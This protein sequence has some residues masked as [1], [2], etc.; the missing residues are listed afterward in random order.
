MAED[1]TSQLIVK[2]AAA[3]VASS[4]TGDPMLALAGFAGSAYELVRKVWKDQK[5]ARDLEEAFQDA[6]ICFAWE[7]GKKENNDLQSLKDW[8]GLTP[9]LGKEIKDLPNQM[10]EQGI[11]QNL[12][13]QFSHMPGITP[14]QARRA[15]DLYESCL[16]KALGP[17]KDY[18]LTVI[19]MGVQRLEEAG[20]QQQFTLDQI[21]A[22]VQIIL[23][24]IRSGL[25]APP[26]TLKQILNPLNLSESASTIWQA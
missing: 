15:V 17:V 9:S 18:T 23:Q 10:D 2:F 16:R 20:K 12:I 13:D 26:K 8:P 14:E 3:L 1:D 19:R 21:L 7:C 22:I 6:Q 25:L 5:K 11:R 24:E 4:A